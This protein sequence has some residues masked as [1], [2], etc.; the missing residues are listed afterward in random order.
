MGD[1]KAA[2]TTATR[3]VEVAG[4]RTR[5][6][7]A[8]PRGSGSGSDR[9]TEAVVFIHGNPGSAGDWVGPAGAVGE[10]ARAVAFDLPDFGHSVASEG[11]GHTVPE[12]SAFTGELIGSLG[13]E[14]VH[15]VLHDFGGPIGLLW[16]AA[17]LD[18]VASVTLFNTG[19]MTGYRWHRAARIWQTPVLGELSM[20][21]LNRSMFRKA[22][23]D[24]EPQGL[25]AAFI[26]EMYD[27]YD[28]RTRR[29]VLDLYRSAKDIR[30]ESP[31]VAGVLRPADIPCLVVWGARDAYLPSKFAAAQRD[32]F[33]SADVNLIEAGGHW[34]FIDHPDRSIELLTGFLKG[35]VAAS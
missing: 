27:N 3:T 13:I 8:G 5:L 14:P 1:E 33:P 28:R 21:V 23:D 29:A 11:F 6:V 24:A 25:P 35:R 18:S 2:V 10:F 15:L 17:N 31:A 12:Y 30:E 32:A 34:P 16:A 4:T 20:I 19:L 26:D 22:I 7:E 9:A